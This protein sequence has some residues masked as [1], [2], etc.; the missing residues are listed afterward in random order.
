MD[1]SAGSFNKSP[2][3]AFTP[4]QMPF[5]ARNYAERLIHGDSL[6]TTKLYKT[7]AS[8]LHH[9]CFTEY[10]T[11]KCKWSTTTFNQVHWD[12][13]KT[14]FTSL[15]RANQVMVAKLQHN[16]INTNSQNAWYYGKSPLCPCCSTTAETL[17][18]FL[19]CP[20]EGSTACRLKALSLLQDDLTSIKTP[21][22]TDA[23]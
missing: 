5:V 22:Q 1:R 8:E 17:E 2:D 21:Q 19:S 7:M 6:L 13:R 12:A 4:K 15:S 18:H 9:K 11:K 16:L 14:A 23:E 10:I 20:S 3:P